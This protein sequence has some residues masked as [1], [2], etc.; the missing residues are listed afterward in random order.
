MSATLTLK[1]SNTSGLIANL[2]AFDRRYQRDIR[3]LNRDTAADAL[4]IAKQL[5]PKDTT[6]MSTQLR[7]DFSDAGLRWSLGWRE[8]DFVG[9]I[10]PF[11]GKAIAGFYP[12]WVELGTAFSPPQPTL[13]PTFNAIVPEY[14]D[15]LR[16]LTAASVARAGI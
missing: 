5:C 6:Y 13:R 1:V 9:Q 8:E 15:N 16:A 3:E 2:R 4:A 10:N 12:L 14:I 11:D 7:V